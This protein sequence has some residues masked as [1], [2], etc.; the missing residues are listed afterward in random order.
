M[1]TILAMIEADFEPWPATRELLGHAAEAME[2]DPVGAL[3]QLTGTLYARKEAH[4]R[5]TIWHR[6]D[7]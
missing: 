7:K 6:K 1:T 5:F 4:G 3:A 2:R